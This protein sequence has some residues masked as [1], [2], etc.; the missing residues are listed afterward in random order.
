[1]MKKAETLS[2]IMQMANNP[3]AAQIFDDSLKKI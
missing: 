1:M 2:F 3:A